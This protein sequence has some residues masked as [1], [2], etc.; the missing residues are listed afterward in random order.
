V[1][2]S[3]ALLAKRIAAI[4]AVIEG[5]PGAESSTLQGAKGVTLY[6]VK[7][8]M[9]AILNVHH[10]RSV[11]VKCDPH[12]VDVMKAKYAGIGHRGHLDRRFWINASLD[13][14]VPMKEIERLIGHS[15]DN[16]VSKLTRKEKTELGVLDAPKPVK[17]RARKAALRPRLAPPVRAL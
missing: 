8:K 12:L 1:S 4:T 7:D 6:K 11:T 10:V 15:Y 2:L 14:D 3:P 17:P 5:K 9:F 16:I 13:A